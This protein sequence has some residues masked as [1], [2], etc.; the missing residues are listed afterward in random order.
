MKLSPDR[1]LDIEEVL[2]GLEHYRPKRKG[3]SWRN[4]IE[5]QRIGPFVYKNTSANL[6]RSIP[7]CAAHDFSGIDRVRPV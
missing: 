4:K 2:A 3:W 7:L 1:K 6:D 5:D